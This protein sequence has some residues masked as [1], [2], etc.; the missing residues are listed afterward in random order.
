MTQVPVCYCVHDDYWFL[1]SSIRSWNS[2]G[3]VYV[4]VSRL[5]WNGE[6]GD[7]ERCA[8]VARDAGAAV[9]VGDWPDEDLHRRA[10]HQH[11]RSQGHDVVFTPDGDEVVE[12]VL[13]DALLR[14]ASIEVAERVYVHM[15]TY[16]KSAEYVI[17]PREQLTPIVLVDLSKTRHLHIRDFG[18][19]RAFVLGPEHGV[20]HHLS[21]AGPNERIQKKVRSWGHRDEVV[22]GW[23]ERVWL[24]W[25]ADKLMH[26]LH[27]THPPAYGFAERIPVPDILSAI[28]IA[29]AQERTSIEQKVWVKI[30]IVIPLHGGEEDISQCLESLAKFQDLLHEVIVIDNASPDKAAGA[31]ESF[32]FVRLIVNAS[33]AGFAKACNQGIDAASGDVI[34]FLNSDTVVSRVGFE[35]LIETLMSSGSI[36][37][38]GPFTN[39]CGHNQKIEPTYTS[40][41]TLDLFAEDFANRDVDDVDAPC[42]MLVGFCLAVRKSVLDEV[43][44]FDESF[45]L[46]TFEDND[47]CYRIRRAGYRLILSSRAY[48]HHHGSR[49]LRRISKTPWNL[50]TQNDKKFKAKWKDDLESGFA[51]HLPGTQF[52]RIVFDHAKHPSRR[53]ANAREMARLADIS[54]CMIVKNEERVIGDCLAS[55]KP[56]FNQIV[57][58]DTGSTDRTKEIIKENGAE[59]Y[60]FPWTDSFSEA[61]N[62]SLNYA[63]GKWVFWMDA[64]DTL[65]F[66]SGMMIQQDALN[67]PKDITAFIVP[68][69]FVDEG[70]GAGTRVDHVKLF[71]NDPRIR[72]EFRIHEQNLGTIRKVGGNIARSGAVVLHSGYD[73]SEEGQARKRVR[74]E[75]LLKLDLEEHPDHPFVL[76]NLGMTAHFTNRH[77]E[78]IDWL[79]RSIKVSEPSESH[80]RKAYALLANSQKALG[81]HEE[82]LQT[83][84]TGLNAVGED[85]E[86]K[87]QAGLLLAEMKR[88][89]EARQMYESIP[90]DIGDH[91]S[92][93][94]MAILTFKRFHNLAGVCMLM[95]DYP[96]AKQWWLKALE[97][98]PS[99]VPS[100]LDLFSHALDLGD[101]PT[102]K[103]VV[104]HVRSAVGPCEE[105]AQ[106]GSKYYETVGGVEGS[107]RFLREAVRRNPYAWGP[108]IVLSRLLLHA[109][110]EAEAQEHLEML[111]LLGNAEGAFYLGVGATRRG[112]LNS[113]FT[114][115]NRAHEL[116]PTHEETI[117]QMWGLER[118]L[119][120]GEALSIERQA[121]SGGEANANTGLNPQPSDFSPEESWK[122]LV[123]KLSHM[124]PVAHSLVFGRDAS[125]PYYDFLFRLVEQYKPRLVVELGTCTGGSTGYL[126]AG[127]PETRVISVDML[128]HPETVKRLSVFANV[129][130]WTYNTNDRKLREALEKEVAIDILFIDTEHTYGQT[131]TEFDMYAPLV[132]PGGLILLDDI[133]MNGMNR[134]WDHLEM[135]K[136]SLDHLHWSG[137]GV[138]RIVNSL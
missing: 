84:M 100:A 62:E 41:D 52:G 11:M 27:P 76:F 3:P 17:R 77:E 12:P 75:K 121:L 8:T 128:Q 108:R 66:L 25:D 136:L 92:S 105:W 99:F 135:S 104:D 94:D 134:F 124:P 88:L 83:V 122:D 110:R 38:A 138:V 5:A 112:D 16:W 24:H 39:E 44:G 22:N 82:A 54:L 47:L 69:Q 51:S 34:V 61:R 129:E 98:N 59:L 42:D 68:V 14:V 85:A 60:E 72:F 56:F 30:S 102:A 63:K 101:Y 115:M 6:P 19:G 70:P 103:S 137:F 116:N 131:S 133:K 78:A 96:A 73:L 109:N 7:W 9:I 36:G 18:G 132:Q 31:A 58:V 10:A 15:D 57:V 4:F 79:R 49:T 117:K 80:L 45:G 125:N 55:A 87:F 126:A 91:F 111:D 28:K 81:L 113:A 130:L 50:L 13:L 65:P 40:L 26:D 119:E 97:S 123:L 90:S 23:Y 33:N 64:D 1:D 2:A 35:R 118:A 74:D 53:L 127:C 89:A 71:R 95:G 120:A 93:I 20:L 106:I 46:G 114:W 32:D 37:A 67:A 29:P 86:L 43:G 107:E 21:Y 48:V